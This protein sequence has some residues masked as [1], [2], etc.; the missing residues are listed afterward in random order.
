[1]GCE[2]GNFQN[3]LASLRSHLK[4]SGGFIAPAPGEE[5]YDLRLPKGQPQTLLSG[6]IEDSSVERIFWYNLKSSKKD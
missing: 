6:K 5:D 2:F 4:R 3:C 1:M